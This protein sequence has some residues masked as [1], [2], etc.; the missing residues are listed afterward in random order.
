MLLIKKIAQLVLLLALDKLYAQPIEY[1]I[2][3]KIAYF[4]GDKFEIPSDQSKYR[5]D[6]SKYEDI[7]IHAMNYPVTNPIESKALYKKDRGAYELKA[8]R[9][10]FTRD[11]CDLLVNEYVKRMSSKAPSRSSIAEGLILSTRKS[12][13]KLYWRCVC[14]PATELINIP[15]VDFISMGDPAKYFKPEP[16]VKKFARYGLDSLDLREAPYFTIFPMDIRPSF[17]CSKARTPSEKAI[18][19]SAELSGLDR[20]LTQVYQKLLKEGDQE[21]RESQRN[22][23]KKRDDSIVSKRD[24]EVITVLVDLYKER[25]KELDALRK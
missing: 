22:W 13:D 1:F 23:M 7:W 9:I 6:L 5:Y 12:G 2:P 16:F 11:S 21:I 14:I 10:L 8:K 24:Q 15:H 4:P 18:C 3:L 20:Q 25:L 17:D 19:R